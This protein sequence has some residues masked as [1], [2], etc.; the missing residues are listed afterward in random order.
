MNYRMTVAAVLV[1][2][3]C[4]DDPNPHE[5]RICN[6]GNQ[7]TCD[8]PCV[9]GDTGEKDANCTFEFDG[10]TVDCTLDTAAR[11]WPKA[12]GSQRGCCIKRDGVENKIYE[13]HACD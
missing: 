4:A 3:G 2:V 1:T 8:I 7:L 12:F 5:Q 6:F 11:I 10:A 13:W 9:D